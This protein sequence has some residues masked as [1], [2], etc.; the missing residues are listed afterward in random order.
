MRPKKKKN[1][2][3]QQPQASTVRIPFDP[4]VV[5]YSAFRTVPYVM[6]D[7]S[8]KG[9]DPALRFLAASQFFQDLYSQPN[10]QQ[11]LLDSFGGAQTE[12]EIEEDA[13]WNIQAGRG[14]YA[15][16]SS[17]IEALKV[18][19][20]MYPNA[21]ARTKADMADLYIRHRTDP[22]ATHIQS[23]PNPESIE[24]AKGYVQNYSPLTTEPGRRSSPL[25]MGL[26]HIMKRGNVAIQTDE[27][28]SQSVFVHEA[29]HASD[30]YTRFEYGD[31]EKLLLGGSPSQST[32]SSGYTLK[33]KRNISVGE[34]LQDSPDMTR[35]EASRFVDYLTEPTEIKSRLM[36]IRFALK[37]LKLGDYTLEDLKRL[38]PGSRAAEALKELMYVA[39][40]EDEIVRSLNIAY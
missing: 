32:Q 29:A 30:P 22:M 40:N 27:G 9:Q 12:K 3:A 24:G 33:K 25:P 1:Q 13:N 14:D 34:V 8:M 23:T 36:E 7:E 16:S 39:Q 19:S 21:P 38:S 10:V 37:D 28:E 6:P 26:G 5:D 18:L 15:V 2:P 31:M 35:E 20:E 11:A 4:P 17:D